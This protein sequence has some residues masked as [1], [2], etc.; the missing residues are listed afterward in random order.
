MGMSE[1]VAGWDT[2][3]VIIGSSAAALTGLMFVVI[4]LTAEMRFGANDRNSGVDAYAS[5]TVVHFCLVLLLAAVLTSP[6]HTATSL[7]VSLGAVAL[8]GLGY[9]VPVLL[10][11]KRVKA[12]APVA[13]DWIWHV[14][15]P[16]AAYLC[17]VT[18]AILIWRGRYNS[19]YCVGGASL[20]LLYIGIHNAWDT[21]TWMAVH[22]RDPP[23]H[24]S[25]SGGGKA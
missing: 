25:Q 22:G 8:I 20:L 18:C 13:E 9:M 23:D 17:L 11:M 19:L 2:F 12:Y 10:R 5:P 3:Y 16:L 4:T 1:A 21:A 6:K 14:I 24:S 7:G 15:L